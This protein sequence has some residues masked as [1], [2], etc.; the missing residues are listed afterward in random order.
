MIDHVPLV[1]PIVGGWHDRLSCGITPR[2]YVEAVE[3]FPLT[4]ADEEFDTPLV[5]IGEDVE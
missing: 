3:P 4:D 1:D 2:Q 5:V